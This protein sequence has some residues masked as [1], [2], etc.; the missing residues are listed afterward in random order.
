VSTRI[1]ITSLS[2]TNVLILD[3]PNAFLLIKPRIE[4]SVLN[5]FLVTK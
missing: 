2:F 3:V 1:D 5:V 4:E